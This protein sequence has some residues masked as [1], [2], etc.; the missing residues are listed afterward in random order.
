MTIVGTKIPIPGTTLVATVASE[1][2]CA[3][4]NVLRIAKR[5]AEF[6]KEKNTE[7]YII[8]EGTKDGYFCQLCNAEIILAPS[9]QRLEAMG[10]KFTCMDCALKILQ[11]EKHN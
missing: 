1:E 6:D 2:V 11:E 4:P 7:G 3:A 9:G 10:G 8:T 5:K